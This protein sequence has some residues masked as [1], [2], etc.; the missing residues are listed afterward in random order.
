MTFCSIL[1]FYN[2]CNWLRNRDKPSC[3]SKKTLNNLRKDIFKGIFT[4]SYKE[5][6]SNNT[7]DYISNLT[8]DINLIENNY[9][10][11]ILMMIG[12]IIIFLGTVIV[13]SFINVW[14][15]LTLFITAGFM[16]IVPGT[17]SKPMKNIQNK[18][19]NKLSDFTIN[20]KEMFLGYEV[21]KSH[22]VEK[23]LLMNLEKRILN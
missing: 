23:I 12:D 3:I 2:E 19:S 20:I 13:L 17:L 16:L 10:I 15:T 8:N 14:V 5:F 21:I 9:I 11:P 18:L 22:S 6:N 4:K 1:F 7:A